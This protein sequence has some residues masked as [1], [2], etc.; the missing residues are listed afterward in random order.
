VSAGAYQNIGSW[1]ES[2]IDCVAVTDPYHPYYGSG[3]QEC[4]WSDTTWFRGWYPPSVGGETAEPYIV[5]L[6]R[7]GFTP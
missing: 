5:V 7:W 3:Y 4:Y 1:T 2:F 6:D